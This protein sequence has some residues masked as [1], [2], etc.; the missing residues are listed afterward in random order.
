MFLISIR[1][2]EE[3]KWEVIEEVAMDDD[4]MIRHM[5]KSYNEVVTT[6]NEILAANHPDQTK[7]TEWFE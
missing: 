3:G 6:I 1:R 2:H 7:L 5:C 4:S